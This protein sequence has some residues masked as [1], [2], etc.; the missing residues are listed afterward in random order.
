[1]PKLTANVRYSSSGT[2]NDA[3][4]RKATLDFDHG[5]PDFRSPGRVRGI[6]I[7]RTVTFVEKDAAFEVFGSAT[8][9][10][11]PFDDCFEA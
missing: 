9:G 11:Q 4:I 2:I 1:M 8:V 10:S 3:G 6:G 7:L 5:S